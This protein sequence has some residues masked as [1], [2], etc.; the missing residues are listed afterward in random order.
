MAAAAEYVPEH[1][2]WSRLDGIDPASPAARQVALPDAFADGTCGAPDFAHGWWEARR[3]AWDAFRHSK[4][5]RN[6]K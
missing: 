4:T 1:R 5:G 2:A 6:G 3:A